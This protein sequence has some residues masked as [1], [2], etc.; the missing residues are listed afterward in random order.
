[1][2]RIVTPGVCSCLADLLDDQITGAFMNDDLVLGT[3]VSWHNEET[4]AVSS[5]GLVLVSGEFQ[6]LRAAHAVALAENLD[7]HT[8]MLLEFRDPLVDVAEPVLIRLHPLSP[9]HRNEL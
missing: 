9:V 3:L 2:A 4:I 8:F 6:S 1:V 7:G 5:N